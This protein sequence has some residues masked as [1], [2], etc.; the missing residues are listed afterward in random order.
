MLDYLLVMISNS[1]FNYHPKWPCGSTICLSELSIIS[2]YLIYISL[3]DVLI[4]QL[5][6]KFHLRL[7]IFVGRSCMTCRAGYCKKQKPLRKPFLF[8][9]YL[10]IFVA[11]I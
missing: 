7:C 11:E 2:P 5:R 6:G 10:I 3:L 1:N 8:F 4:K 9:L